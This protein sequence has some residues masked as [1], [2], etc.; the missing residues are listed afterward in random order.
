MVKNTASGVLTSNIHE[1]INVNVIFFRKLKIIRIV[2]V[3]LL[4]LHGTVVTNH[5]HVIFRWIVSFQK[6]SNQSLVNVAAEACFC[7]D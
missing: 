5:K 3:C 6:F 4:E 1:R 2:D 7:G